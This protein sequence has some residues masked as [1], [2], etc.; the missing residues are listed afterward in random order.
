Y[1]QPAREA[2]VRLCLAPK[3]KDKIVEALIAKA[4]RV[5]HG[6]GSDPVRDNVKAFECFEQAFLPDIRSFREHYLRTESRGGVPFEG[7]SIT[8]LPHFAATDN[9][10]K[11]RYAFLYPSAWTSKDLAAYLEILGF[12]IEK[13]FKKDASSIWCMNLRTGKSVVY[14]PSLRL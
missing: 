12:I 3:M 5:P 1:Y 7:V 9:D 2:I 10:G 14:K 6:K 4:R 13:K 11:E 8:G